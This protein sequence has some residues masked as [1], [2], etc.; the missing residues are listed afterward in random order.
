MYISDSTG[1]ASLDPLYSQKDK[2]EDADFSSLA[3]K[4]HGLNIKPELA[5]LMYVILDPDVYLPKNILEQ[6]RASNANNN[7]NNN[8]YVNN[9]V[10]GGVPGQNAPNVPTITEEDADSATAGKAPSTAEETAGTP[11]KSQ[12]TSK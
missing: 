11:P 4:L 2:L 5:T 10:D 6:N 3:W 8:S 12:E 9:E 7:N 1:E